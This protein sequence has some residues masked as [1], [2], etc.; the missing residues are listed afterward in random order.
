M[1]TAELTLLPFLAVFHLIR[2]PRPYQSN[3]LHWIKLKSLLCT[4]FQKR[5][6]RNPKLADLI[7]TRGHV[8]YPIRVDS[9]SMKPLEK[10]K[11]KRR[12][13][14]S[15]PPA[16]VARGNPFKRL[17]RGKN[18]RKIVEKY[19]KENLGQH[20]WRYLHYFDAWFNLTPAPYQAIPGRVLEGVV[21]GEGRSKNTL[22]SLLISGDSASLISIDVTS[23][24]H[25]AGCERRLERMRI[26]KF[27]QE[28]GLT[29][30]LLAVRAAPTWNRCHN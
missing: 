29:K 26:R 10:N 8:S 11:K 2:L 6:K 24:S 20:S 3:C 27:G 5:K 22:F 21:R 15:Q 16:Q 14:T 7:K 18:T 28:K 17:K 30:L 25:Y 19:L 9:R 23:D 4:Y 12:V 1:I 13:C